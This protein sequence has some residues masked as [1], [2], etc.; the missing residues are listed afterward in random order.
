[1]HVALHGET[2]LRFVFISCVAGV[3]AMIIYYKG[4]KS[5][6]AGQV[7]FIDRVTRRSV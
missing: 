5:M 1:M 2:L 4:L 3:I 6:P 7:S